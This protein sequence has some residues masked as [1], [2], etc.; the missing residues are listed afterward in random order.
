MSPKKRA[1]GADIE[2]DPFGE[3]PRSIISR[4]VQMM[5]GRF[6]FESNRRELI[7]LVEEAYVGLPGHRFSSTPPDFTVRLTVSPTAPEALRRK[8]P[9]RKRTEPAPISML[10][11]AGFLG[12]ATESST[13]VLISPALRTALI[14]VNRQALAFPYHARYELLEFAVFTLASRAQQ[15]VPLHAACIGINGNGVLL[16]GETGAGKTT[17]ALHCLL[18][19]FDFLAEDSVFVEPETL[20]ATA[21]ANFLHVRSDSLRWLNEA[22]RKMIRGSPVIRRRSG[23]AK[24]EVDLRRKEFRLAPAPL[25]L[26]AIAYLT[27]ESAR[28]GEMLRPIAHAKS[29]RRLASLQGYGAHLPQWRKFCAKLRKTETVEVHRGKHPSETAKA[30]RILLGEA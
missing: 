17:A 2:S 27:S 21:V 4:Q 3:R 7:R 20:R 11:G 16:I 5:G 26:V 24:Y 28:K 12:A 22:Q 14:S 18:N 25:K 15:L 19:G 1:L 6:L 13:F 9:A 30:L 10:S 8:K 29:I 23:I